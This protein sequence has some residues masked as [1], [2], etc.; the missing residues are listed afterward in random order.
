MYVKN[1]YFFFLK[2]ILREVPMYAPKKQQK[3]FA[4]LDLPEDDLC[5]CFYNLKRKTVGQTN[6]RLQLPCSFFKYIFQGTNRVGWSKQLVRRAGLQMSL[7]VLNIAT[8]KR[9][10]CCC[11]SF[12]EKAVHTKYSLPQ[13]LFIKT[14]EN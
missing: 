14:L 8:C 9:A 7:A 12:W 5:M 1:S 3:L 6:C 11:W 2:A 4:T 13:Q 10:A